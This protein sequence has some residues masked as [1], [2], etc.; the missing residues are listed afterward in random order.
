MRDSELDDLL[1]QAADALAEAVGETPCKVVELS[2]S[3]GN[4]DIVF[5]SWKDWKA[6]GAAWARYTELR[7]ASE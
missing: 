1:Q 6:I 2:E 7:E 3:L 5:L 4:H